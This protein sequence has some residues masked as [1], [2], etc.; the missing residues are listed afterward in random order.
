MR[1]PT[2]EPCRAGS[3]ETQHLATLTRALEM[4]ATETR[5]TMSRFPERGGWI[6]SE[7]GGADGVTAPRTVP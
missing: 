7:A 2:D 5:R 6:A 4:S 1:R 3:E